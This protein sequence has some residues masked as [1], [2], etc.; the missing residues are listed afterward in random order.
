MK[1]EV[2]HCERTF[3]PKRQA[4]RPAPPD[5]STALCHQLAQYQHAHAYQNALGN[6]FVGQTSSN[7]INNLFGLSGLLGSH[8]HGY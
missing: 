3:R 8:F 7:A 2:A 5:Y 1:R 4:P 6:A